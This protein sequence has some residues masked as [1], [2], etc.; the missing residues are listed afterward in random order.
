MDS[1]RIYETHENDEDKIYDEEMGCMPVD[2]NS[3][4]FCL[5]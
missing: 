4:F 5:Q 3:S 1:I 2:L